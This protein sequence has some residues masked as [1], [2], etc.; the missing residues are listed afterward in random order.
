MNKI[1]N[2]FKTKFKKFEAGVVKLFIDHPG[3]E[4]GIDIC[5]LIIK[6][7]EGLVRGRIMSG[8]ILWSI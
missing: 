8:Q 7:A 4:I 6:V 2:W 3:I 5:V 1:K